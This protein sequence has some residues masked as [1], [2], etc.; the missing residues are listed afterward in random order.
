MRKETGSAAVELVLVTPVLIVLL[1]FVVFVGR[2]ASARADVDAAARDGARAASLARSPAAAARDGR[3]AVEATLAGERV[4]CR[5]LSVSIEAASF[6]PGGSVGATVT[7]A[8]DLGDLTSLGVPGTR[9]V[10][11]AFSEPVD[12]FREALP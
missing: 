12:L 3:E 11:A 6:R 8:V 7:C 2:L 4:T 10:S 5:T 9:T 1:L